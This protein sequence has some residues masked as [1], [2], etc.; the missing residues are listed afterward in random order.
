MHPSTATSKRSRP[1][2]RSLEASTISWR[3]SMIPQEIHSSRRRRGVE[4]AGFRERL[5]S[6]GG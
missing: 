2:L 1:I 4:N 3:V 5:L 6:E